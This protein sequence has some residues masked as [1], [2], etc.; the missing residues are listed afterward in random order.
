[1]IPLYTF[2]L[3][4]GVT[5][6]KRIVH[7]VWKN[8]LS[9][10]YTFEQKQMFRRAGL[11]GQLTFV[12]D[13]YYYIVNTPFENT[14]TLEVYV[15]Y[16][17]GISELPFWNGVFYMTDCTVNMDDMTVK[18]RPQTSDRYTKI[19]AGLDKE[20]DLIKLNPVIQ[21]VT[22]TRRPMIQVY[23][24]GDS[25]VSCFLSGM[26]WEQ[27][28]NT[29]NSES[30]LIN[31]YHFG[32]C[33]EFVELTFSGTVPQYLTGTFIGTWPETQAEGEWR[34]FENESHVYYITYFQ[35]FTSIQG[36]TFRYRNGLRVYAESNPTTVL[37]YFQQETYSTDPTADYPDI[38]T[39]ITFT[40][41]RSGVANLTA[42][43]ATTSVFARWVCAGST[44]GTGTTYPIPDGD[45][46][47]NNR[48]YR[49]CFPFGVDGLIIMSYNHSETPTQWGI[50]PDGD[51]YAKPTVSSVNLI[52][53]LPVA[54]TTWGYASIWLAQTSMTN[55]L[56]E[57]G[58]KA[59]ELRDA[60]TLEAV[61]NALLSQIDNTILFDASQVYSRFLYGQNPLM[62]AGWGRLVMTPKS[63]VLV[64]E[65]SEP[66][67]KAPITL[68]Q[69]FDMLRDVCGC[70]WYINDGNQL[71]IEHVSWFKNGGSYSGTQAIGIDITVAENT[72]NGKMLS[73]GT[74]EYRFDKT[75]MPER[76]Q[77]GW[78]DDT[79][80]VFKG[81]P[82]DIVSKFVQT[83]DVE[84]VSVNG[85]NA[86][87]DYMMLNPSNVS[88]D[89]FA[90]LCCAVSNGQYHTNVES[91]FSLVA[92]PVQ[93]WQLTFYSLQQAFLISD[94]PAWHIR[95]N[96]QD[97]LAKG[98]QRK[99]IQQVD[100]PMGYLDPNPTMLVRTG[101]G[102]G[103]IR[104]MN[105][106]LSSRTAKTTIAYDTTQQ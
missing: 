41:T 91:P 49:Y 67:R 98:I 23:V 12:G 73:F 5:D 37:W 83:G 30:T 97:M 85:F 74:N 65:Y 7:P 89:G 45:I 71:I 82:I 75:E 105:L 56:E 42:S 57:Q 34:T 81:E 61:I 9:L 14:F 54:R 38:P 43:T 87:V 70:Y 64:A 33:G 96:G 62:L 28:A 68:G 8:D 76:Y 99:K 4:N 93:N 52:D 16:N 25:V 58:R 66:A 20:F 106:R 88:Q 17:N 55:S 86:D 94:M 10:D 6:V 79:T 31:T 47:P 101:I 36:S 51:Y 39:D 19:L 1:M 59:T 40:S 22:V 21:P 13:D 32:K 35:E 92:K 69:V 78:M 104:Q 26:Q 102:L 11:S 63:N 72:R 18:V 80:D 60:F 24:P 29:E 90:L 44:F 50:R 100:I 15:S 3:N 53:L 77:Y 27:D 103:E 2:K 84:E 46:V 95:V 48:N